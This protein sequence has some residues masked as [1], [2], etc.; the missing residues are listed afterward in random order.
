[1]YDVLVLQYLSYLLSPMASL[2]VSAALCWPTVVLW[3]YVSNVI[4]V[5]LW[6]S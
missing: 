1:M 6:P 5:E 3:L 4:F 2:N